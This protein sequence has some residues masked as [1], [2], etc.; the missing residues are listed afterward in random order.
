MF[1]NPHFPD[2]NTKFQKIEMNCWM[3]WF[4]MLAPGFDP[5]PKSEG[6]Y[7]MM[8]YFIFKI[9]DMHLCACVHIEGNGWAA[10][11]SQPGHQMTVWFFCP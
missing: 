9:T 1:Y 6:L 4:E 11:A 5:G 3:L 7:A 2:E 10:Y 8:N